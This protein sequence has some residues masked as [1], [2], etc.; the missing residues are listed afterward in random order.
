M[1]DTRSNLTRRFGSAAE[2]REEAQTNLAAGSLWV[3]LAAAER[4]PLLG[5]VAITLVLAEGD[6][7]GPLAGRVTCVAP[8]GVAIVLDDLPSAE[9]VTRLLGEAPARAPDELPPMPS[10][11]DAGAGAWGDLPA[12]KSPGAARVPGE[13]AGDIVPAEKAPVAPAAASDPPAPELLPA[14]RTFAAAAATTDAAPAELLP[15]V[16][17]TAAAGDA[18]AMAALLAPPEPAPRLVA[19]PVV[20]SAAAPEAA[21]PP[22]SAGGID[23]PVLRRAEEVPVPSVAEAPG[24]W[25]DDLA[26]ALKLPNDAESEPEGT[27]AEE[28]APDTPSFTVRY[29]TPAEL[30]EAYRGELGAGRLRL[31][32]SGEPPA[33]DTRVRVTAM[34]PELGALEIDGIVVHRASGAIGVR[35]ELDG[36]TRGLLES[37]LPPPS[38]SGAAGNGPA[39]AEAPPPAAP[40]APASG[41]P[42]LELRQTEGGAE[43]VV[44]FDSL[45]DF[46][47]EYETNI[48]RGGVMVP[49]PERPPIRSRVGVVFSLMGGK[50]EVKANGEVVLHTPV[51]IGVQLSEL[52]PDAKLEI[53]ALL[54]AAGGRVGGSVDTPPPQ[55]AAIVTPP[56]PVAS[57]RTVPPAGAAPASPAA[58]PAVAFVPAGSRFEGE[59]VEVLREAEVEGEAGIAGGAIGARA[60]W[61]KV[62]ATLQATRAGGVLQATRKG[63]TK[64]FLV[65]QGR[66]VDAKGEPS[67]E[68]ESLLRVIRKHGLAKPGVLRILEKA[69]DRATDEAA[70]LSSQNVWTPADVD[71]A[72]RWQVLERAAEVFGWERG[73]F[74][75]DPDGDHGWARATAG[76]PPGQVIL[77]GM[78]TY[79]R[80]S[81]EDLARILRA[82][83]DR[84]V[85]IVQGSGFE[86][87]RAGMNDKELKLWADIDGKK[88]LRQILNTT[89][90]GVSAT[91]RLVFA[92]CRLGVL[93]LDRAGATAAASGGKRE[94][95]AESLRERV[96]DMKQRDLFGRLGLSWMC[97]AVH[98]HA[99][100]DQIRRELDADVRGGGAAAEPAREALTLAEDAWRNLIDTRNRRVQRLRIIEDPARIESAAEMLAERATIL[101]MQGDIPGAESALQMAVDLAPENGA[102][103]QALARLKA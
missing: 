100:W 64:T 73:R 92:L 30:E 39:I 40:V 27:P 67:R 74:R 37:A 51:G 95:R 26:P 72:R 23:F 36:A 21:P 96:A 2:A 15:A 4:P 20:E 82:G 91:H 99:A 86:P 90:I 3:P 43:V 7:L 49:T 55:P 13:G 1:A 94:D 103:V 18:A 75:F 58:R 25:A 52:S 6:S 35:L 80:A 78:R 24:L 93:A 56:P 61:L 8:G 46:R 81:G 68:D 50:R 42:T 32:V 71:R 79:I 70:A 98:V 48:R 53:D 29:A 65:L 63:E 38:G 85:R 62:L 76:V 69:L 102:Y 84:V 9:V 22:V 54:S 101:K 28:S 57:V 11:G 41:K 45:A 87:A 47:R 59:L 17:S 66:I 97:A 19:D 77:H 10:P 14:M 89:P 31:P 88:T 44:R 33:I 12:A 60:S 34:L 16:R 83:M 5:A